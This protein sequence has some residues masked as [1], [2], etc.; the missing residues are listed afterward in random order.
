MD[1]TRF[2]CAPER[3]LGRDDEQLTHD[4][5]LILDLVQEC[6]LL[7]GNLV[8]PIHENLRRLNWNVLPRGH[9]PWEMLRPLIRPTIERFSDAAKPVIE[10]RLEI[11]SRYPHDFV[12]I[13]K[14]GF[15][16]YVIFA[17]PVL[18]I[19]VLECTHDGNAT[20][21][22]GDDWEELSQWSKAEVL[23]DNRHLH[24]LIHAR[25]WQYSLG[26]VMRQHGY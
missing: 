22:F 15:A 7:S 14:A 17:F 12:A 3:I 24:R 26:D 13:G 6:E 25:G 11:V 20:Y 18:G 4:V 19:Y 16:G 1:G 9:Y 8:S 5:N 23:R 10:H 21:V 2:V